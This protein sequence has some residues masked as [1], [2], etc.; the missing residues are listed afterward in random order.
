MADLEEGPPVDQGMAEAFGKLASVAHGPLLTLSDLWQELVATL[1]DK[2][3]LTR[4][5]VLAMA[6]RIAERSRLPELHDNHRQGLQI[7]AER[8]REAYGEDSEQAIS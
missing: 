8:L 6:D 3:T 2:G 5:E 4:E 1:V 7:M